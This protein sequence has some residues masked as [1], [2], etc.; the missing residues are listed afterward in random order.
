MCKNVENFCSRRG[1]YLENYVKSSKNRLTMCSNDFKL[2]V[3]GVFSEKI[4]STLRTK[5]LY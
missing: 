3:F 5:N 2:Q 1:G 4:F